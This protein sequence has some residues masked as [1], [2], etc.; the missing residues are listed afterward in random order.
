[1]YDLY[2]DTNAMFTSELNSVKFFTVCTK[3]AQ[4]AILALTGLRIPK[5]VTSSG[6][7]QR[8]IAGLRAQNLTNWAKQASSCKT[9]T[10]GSLS[11]Q[12]RGYSPISYVRYNF[13]QGGFCV[14]YTLKAVFRMFAHKVQISFVMLHERQPSLSGHDLGL[15][16][17]NEQYDIQ[18]QSSIAVPKK[19]SKILVKC[20]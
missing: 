1:M 4:M 12:G 19:S 18:T 17:I 5:I 8:I 6:G 7:M 20:N 16:N 13:R 3:L 9:E 11:S 14:Y 10:L 2:I 15:M